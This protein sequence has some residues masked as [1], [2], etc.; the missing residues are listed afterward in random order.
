M[1]AFDRISA[2]TSDETRSYV[3]KTLDLVERIQAILQSKGMTQ[4]D[5]A[6][7]LEKSPSEISRWMTGLHHFNLKT[8]I[9]IEEV[10][11]EEV[12]S[13]SSA[14]LAGN[15]RD[16][17]QDTAQM[18]INFDS[19]PHNMRQQVIDFTEFLLQKSS[20]GES[21]S[22]HQKKSQKSAFSS[23]NE[24]ATEYRKKKG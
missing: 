24:P 14:S 23:V 9:K 3:A 10:L 12:I 20:E 16:A 18:L 15:K 4:K 13:A 19:L 21:Y 2:R 8:L 5:L 17:G 6:E 1:S 7:K 22:S 11:G